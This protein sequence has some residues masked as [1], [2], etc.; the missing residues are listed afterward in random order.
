MKPL[1]YDPSWDKQRLFSEACIRI[2]DV[3]TAWRIPLPRI[4]DTSPGKD[5]MPGGGTFYGLFTPGNVYVAESMR[6]Y[7]WNPDLLRLGRPQRF[8][9]I[10]YHFPILHR[11]RWQ[12]LLTNAP[13]FII[14]NATAWIN[15]GE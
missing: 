15:K 8:A 6:I 5:K 10:S 9:F 12:D 4:H 7:I 2:H 1:I 13:E 11:V 3:S 14:D